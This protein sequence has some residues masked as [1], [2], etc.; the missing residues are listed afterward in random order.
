MV[1][2]TLRRRMSALATVLG[3]GIALPFALGA[4]PASARALIDITKT[5]SGSFPR[6]GQGVY[7]ITVTNP[8]DQTTASGTVMQDTIQT[9]GVTFVTGTVIDSDV[10]VSCT[11]EGDNRVNCESEPLDP[12]E[13]YTLT[14]TVNVAEDAPCTVDNFAVALVPGD[15]GDT[16]EDPTTITGG[17]CGGDEGDGDGD[18]SPVSI[19]PVNLTGVIPMFNNIT[20]NNNIHS[21][22]ASN[23][24]RQAFGLNAP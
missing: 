7:T 9:G 10:N 20:T 12:G 13:G 19:L 6:G 5:H 1:T 22:G 15:V 16:A 8:G 2:H 3:L 21:P 24:S 14:F 4:T 11:F 18:G 23:A 17:T